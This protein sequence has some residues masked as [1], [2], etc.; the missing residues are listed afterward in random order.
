MENTVTK[1]EEEEG[2]KKKKKEGFFLSF[3]EKASKEGA[4]RC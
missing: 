3:L 2:E 4:V 1:E